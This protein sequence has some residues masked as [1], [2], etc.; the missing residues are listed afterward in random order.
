[1]ALLTNVDVKCGKTTEAPLV[2]AVHSS[3]ALNFTA[4]PHKKHESWTYTERQ[5]CAS[6]C[7]RM[8]LSIGDGKLS[9]VVLPS[10]GATIEDQCT[11]SSH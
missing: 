4:V 11:A 3:Q 5:M 9:L 6:W 7:R 1:M 8:F 2:V 10:S